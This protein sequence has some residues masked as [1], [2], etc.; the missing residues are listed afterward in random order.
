MLRDEGH[1][2]AGW[3][4]GGFAPSYTTLPHEHHNVYC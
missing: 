2:A 3:G 1:S 4:L